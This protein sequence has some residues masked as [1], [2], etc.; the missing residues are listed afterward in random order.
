MT[1][2]DKSTQ[3]NASSSEELAKSSKSMTLESQQ[4]VEMMRFFTMSSD[5][6]ENNS[7]FHDPTEHNMNAT[8][9]FENVEPVESRASFPQVE[10]KIASTSGSWKTF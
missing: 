7:F 8:Q 4:L 10:E 9:S 2:L 5:S 3:S 6:H 1:D